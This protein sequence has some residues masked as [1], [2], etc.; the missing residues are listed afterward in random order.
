MSYFY[1]GLSAC[2]GGN[3]PRTLASGLSPVQAGQT[4][5]KLYRGKAVV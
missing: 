1:H 2:T 4:V 3:N 5:V